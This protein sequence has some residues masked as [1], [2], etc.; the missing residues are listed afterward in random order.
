M[1]N[2]T[3]LA[4]EV[5]HDTRKLAVENY[6]RAIKAEEE[7][8]L[9]RNEIKVQKKFYELERSQPKAATITEEQLRKLVK[10][11]ND[12]CETNEPTM[13]YSLHCIGIEVI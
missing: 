11:H 10:T 9:L 2:T 8:E 7:V 12:L 5:L 1:F 6:N 3:L 4:L 13:R